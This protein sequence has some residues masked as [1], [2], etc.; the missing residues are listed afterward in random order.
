MPV[1]V[2][3]LTS[4]CSRRANIVN[5]RLVLKNPGVG[6]CKL[7]E[8]RYYVNGLTYSYSTGVKL[9]TVNWK[10]GWI[11]G[12][13]SQINLKT[14]GDLEVYPHGEFL[15]RDLKV[16][17]YSWQ[18][19]YHYNYLQFSGVSYEKDCCSIVAPGKIDENLDP[20]FVIRSEFRMWNEPELLK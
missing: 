11:T 16:E 1:E 18:R 8:F 4:L 2:H 5:P 20:R 12:R 9:V 3:G 6:H 14:N 15:V 13:I 17:K 7:N 10:G 19:Q